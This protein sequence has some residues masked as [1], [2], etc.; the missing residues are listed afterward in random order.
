MLFFE[1][2]S[3]H[4][5]RRFHANPIFSNDLITT[6]V[7]TLIKVILC[8]IY[9]VF[10]MTIIPHYILGDMMNETKIV[11]QWDACKKYCKASFYF[12]SISSVSIIGLQF[13]LGP[14]KII[15]QNN[16]MKERSYIIFVIAIDTMYILFNLIALF[17]QSDYFHSYREECYHWDANEIFYIWLFTVLFIGLFEVIH[18]IHNILCDNTGSETTCKGLMKHIYKYIRW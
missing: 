14:H 7:T 1:I 11:G 3:F 2:T 6:I 18:T 9:L 12:F 17:L 10:V 16:S 15:Q 5:I 8:L 13:F 4:L